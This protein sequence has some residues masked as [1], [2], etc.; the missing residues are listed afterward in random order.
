M[1]RIIDISK[2]LD[3]SDVYT[4]PELS[5]I[6]AMFIQNSEGS[7]ARKMPGFDYGRYNQHESCFHRRRNWLAKCV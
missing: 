7:I 4:E 6:A 1:S 5:N 3:Q 2:G